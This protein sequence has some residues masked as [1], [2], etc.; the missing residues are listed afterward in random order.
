MHEKGAL[1][2]HLFINLYNHFIADNY[3][4][5]RRYPQPFYRIIELFLGVPSS[6]RA[7]GNHHQELYSTTL[8]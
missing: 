6:A 7:L 5:S 2:L 4:K 1:L 3:D 8:A